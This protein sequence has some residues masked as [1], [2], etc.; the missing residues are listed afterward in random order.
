MDPEKGLLRV[1]NA[2]HLITMQHNRFAYSSVA[3]GLRVT[4]TLCDSNVFLQLYWDLDELYRALKP[5]FENEFILGQ[6]PYIEPYILDKIGSM[7]PNEEAVALSL[8]H[9]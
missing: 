8:I 2:T 7:N 3:L 1:L 4:H 5:G 9:I 6:A